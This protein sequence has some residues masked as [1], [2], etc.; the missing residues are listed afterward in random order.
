[1]TALIVDLDGPILEGSRR[2][3]AVYS[4]ILREAGYRPLGLEEYWGLKRHRTSRRSML[5]RSGAEKIYDRFA[6]LWLDRIESQ[7][8]LSLDQLQ[9]GAIDTLESWS[10]AGIEIVLVTARRDR[11]ALE[12]Q[13]ER[14]GIRRLLARVLVAPFSERGSEKARTLLE[15]RPGGASS[16]RAWIG[17][18]ELDIEAAKQI[19]VLSVGVTCG[20]R[21]R[22]FLQSLEADFL[23]DNLEEVSAA[24][25]FLEVPLGN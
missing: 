6:A 19:G 13:L 17:D 7:G 9:P 5:E 24:H 4:Q 11:T 2:H 12:A 22:E 20:L 25:S 21:S 10:R 18:T 16:A 15:G 14:M 1:V 23:H 3:H 8:M